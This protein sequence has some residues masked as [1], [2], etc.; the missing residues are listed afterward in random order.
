MS[1]TQAPFT[2]PK[3]EQV[4]PE[5]VRLKDKLSH[6]A[7]AQARYNAHVA[8]VTG[9]SGYSAGGSG[10]KLCTFRLTS[11]DFADTNTMCLS[12][13]AKGDNAAATTVAIEEG[14]LSLVQQI[15]VRAGG[16][17]L[18]TLL[19]VPAAYAACVAQTMP[20]SVYETEGP[21]AGLWRHNTTL[22]ASRYVLATGGS[23]GLPGAW[24][25]VGEAAAVKYFDEPCHRAA[26]EAAASWQVN[27]R[28]YSIPLGWLLGLD[29]F[30]ALRNVSNLEIELLF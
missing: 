2:S 6:S 23:S 4:V 26:R 20:K 3:F 24:E 5:A 7:I 14:A 9:S 27:G 17:P 30:F 29:R 13:F 8:P 11:S 21:V 12:F 18:F 10:A 25:L 1:I 15:T 16:T 22:G 28:F 19:D